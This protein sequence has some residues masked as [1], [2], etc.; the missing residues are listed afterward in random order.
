MNSTTFSDMSKSCAYCEKALSVA[1]VDLM[2][3]W[4]LEFSLY[5]A[6]YFE[7]FCRKCFDKK[8]PDYLKTKWPLK[9]IKEWG[10]LFEVS[11][12]T[13]WR[14]AGF[15][16]VD[17]FNWTDLLLED[18][19]LVDI[20]V[21]KEW[22]QFGFTS[23]NYQDWKEWSTDP[24]QISNALILN[25]ETI[26]NVPA[27]ELGFRALGFNLSQAIRLSAAEFGTDSTVCEPE[28]YIS[29][30]I[31]GGLNVDELIAL[32]LQVAEKNDVFEE[33]HR[34]CRE[35]IN[36]WKPSFGTYLPK[37]LG[38]LR[39]AGLPIT[40]ENLLRYWGLS[41]AQILKAIDMGTDVEFASNL[42]R[43]GVSASKVKI[44][45]LLIA[46]GIDQD[47]ALLLTKR[48]FSVRTVNEIESW[49]YSIQ[50]LVSLVEE[51]KT[52][53]ATEIKQWLLCG[54][55]AGYRRRWDR[56][57]SVWHQ[58]GFKPAEAYQWFLDGFQPSEAYAWSKSGAKTPTVAKRR[59]EAGITPK[60]N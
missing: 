32:K 58:Y 39:E 50:C 25:G 45:E 2:S 54:G 28:D 24:K 51:A 36:D 41:K 46:K 12:A 1:D 15:D 52:L 59:K 44:A 26:D 5:E 27:P 34:E 4:L 11:M 55:G 31:A 9:E 19:F 29:N 14:D 37:V 40:C 35:N 42:V 17:A 13:I 18:Y 23:L 53:G 3:S 56:Q 6:Q 49:G 48:G 22:K 47:S 33:K 43:R 7:M 20:E 16:A 30:W 21:A 8:Y 57:I 60:T 38:A 10:M